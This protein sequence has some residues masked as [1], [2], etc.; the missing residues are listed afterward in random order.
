MIVFSL[1]EIFA[2]SMGGWVLPRFKNLFVPDGGWYER[3]L[4]AD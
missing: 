1:N 4:E 2:R 3:G